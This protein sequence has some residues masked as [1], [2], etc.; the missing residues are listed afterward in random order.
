MCRPPSSTVPD[1]SRRSRHITSA[2]SAPSICGRPDAITATSYDAARASS[3]RSDP[4]ITP[5]HADAALPRHVTARRVAR[6][7]PRPRRRPRGRQGRSPARSLD[8]APAE[9]S[10]HRAD[11]RP[12]DAAVPSWPT[13]TTRSAGSSRP[14]RTAPYWKNTAILVLEDDAQDGPDHVDAHRS[15]VLVISAYNRPGRSCTRCT[16]PSR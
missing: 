2:R 4:L 7:L 6:G 15:P 10:H 13:T 8:H 12:A 5:D 3:A 1:E 16:T 9:R 14:S 11:P